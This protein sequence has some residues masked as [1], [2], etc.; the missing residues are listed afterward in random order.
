M[1]ET[2]QLD[3]IPERAPGQPRGACLVDDEGGVDSVPL[4]TATGTDNRSAVAPRPRQPFA[5]HQ[6]D[7]RRVLA[8]RR[9]GVGQPPQAVLADDVGC[10]DVT[11][12]SGH[13]VARPCRYLL[14]KG[15]RLNGPRPAVAARCP[16]QTMSGRQQVVRTVLIGH[17]GVVHHD[18]VRRE[19]LTGPVP[20]LCDAGR[21]CSQS[22][23]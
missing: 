17:D 15:G 12:E 16:L 14:H 19:C 10:P 1:V 9:A 6:T 5:G 3:T 22:H 2:R 4:A 21:R 23:Y 11:P 13:G 8:E 7:G 18:S 20:V